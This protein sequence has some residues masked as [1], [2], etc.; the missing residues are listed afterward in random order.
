MLWHDLILN[1]LVKISSLVRGIVNH[2]SNDV[3]QPL[4]KRLDAFAA[5]TFT[6]LGAVSPHSEMYKLLSASLRAL[7]IFRVL[8]TVPQRN[9]KFQPSKFLFHAN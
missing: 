7:A 9:F 3:I 4:P 2:K 8:M 6:S 1:K 5:R